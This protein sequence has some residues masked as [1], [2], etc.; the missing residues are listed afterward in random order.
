MAGEEAG[1]FVELKCGLVGFADRKGD[2]AV[3]MKRQLGHAVAEQDAAEVASAVSGGDAEL[4][5]VGDVGRDAGGEQ[6]GDE[7]VG[8]TFAD[9]EGAKGIEGAAAGE[10]DDVVEEAEGAI[11]GAV[12]VVDVGVNVVGVGGLDEGGGGLVEGFGPGA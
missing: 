9:G 10:A 6:D 4:R 7:G 3:A 8:G 11:Q 1:C 5:D 2:G 12:L